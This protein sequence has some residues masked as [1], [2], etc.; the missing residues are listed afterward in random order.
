MSNFAC[1]DESAT[2]ESNFGYLTA[3]L[4]YYYRPSCCVWLLCFDSQY[5]SCTF[6][7]KHDQS[8]FTISRQEPPLRGWEFLF[9]SSDNTIYICNKSCHILLIFDRI[10]IRP[11]VL[12]DVSKRD[13][14]ATILG[15]HVPFPIGICPSA[16][17]KHNGSDG[18]TATARG[19]SNLLLGGSFCHRLH[20]TSPR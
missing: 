20:S 4:I 11:R 7:N 13:L 16:I 5:L 9:E 2:N 8:M 10:R 12:R 6:F 15:K 14:S 19:R 3:L 17:Q 18:E 1:S